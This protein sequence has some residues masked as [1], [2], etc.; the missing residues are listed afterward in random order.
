MTA[1]ETKPDA[2]KP[3][4]KPYGVLTLAVRYGVILTIAMLVLGGGIGFLVSG[5]PGLFGALIGAGLTAVLMALSAASFLLAV[6]VTKGDPLN[7]LFYAV[8]L[9][10]SA[11]KIV[12]F[13]VIM[14][15]LRDATFLDPRVMYVA[16]IVAV[17]GSLVVDLLAFVRA[18]VPYVTVDLPGGQ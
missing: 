13:L 18:R 4:Y 11:L 14:L 15:T 5:L 6:R 1:P 7:P 10:A 8:V 3:D 9:G 17:A 12:A 2:A 16:V